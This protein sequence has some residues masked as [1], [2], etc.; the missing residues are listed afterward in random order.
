[1]GLGFL[2]F[3]LTTQVQG[4][5]RDFGQQSFIELNRGETFTLARKLEALTKPEQFECV[6]AKKAGI[7][8][9]EEKKG[10]CEAGF[11]RERGL[12]SEPNSEIQI[13]FFLSP[14][15]EFIWGLLA[16]LMLQLGLAAVMVYSQ[17]RSFFLQHKMQL[18]LAALAR[19]V[20]HDIRSPLAVLKSLGSG[21]EG[22]SGAAAIRK[23]ALVRLQNLA[24]HL[25][26]DSKHEGRE[27]AGE[28]LPALIEEKSVEF[29]GSLVEIFI[30]WEEES[31]K[32][33]YLGDS[34][35]LRRALSNLINNSAEAGAKRVEI[36][37]SENL[38]D[39][40]CVISVGD[41]GKGMAPEILA[42]VGRK[43][44]TWGKTRGV[45]LGVHGSRQFVEFL[46]GTLTVNSTLGKGT[47]VVILLPSEKVVSVA[48]LIEDDEALA[49]LWKVVAAKR[50]IDL[51][52]F[53][54]PEEFEAKKNG[55]PLSARIYLDL[56]FENSR[57][58]PERFGER[59]AAEGYE[60]FLCSGRA[61]LELSHFPWAKGISSKEPPW[62]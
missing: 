36:R 54:S 39:G 8:F 59:L 25:L 33:R 41:D 12:V 20:G 4:F 13:E 38:L 27:P 26:G 5:V 10:K 30:V 1:M 48:V 57:A 50:G 56:H 21:E 40:K 55:V 22:L 9:F 7:T 2:R 42:K 47:Q 31:L 29:R 60:V 46:G 19:Q 52:H 35:V 51:F 44:F 24:S 37:I 6:M 62:L 53:K 23:N 61:K 15:K 58:N 3:H 34:F 11:L 16:F 45:G 28:W 32:G 14:Q 43:N 49:A 18:E 17:R